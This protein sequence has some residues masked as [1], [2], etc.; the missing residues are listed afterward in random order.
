MPKEIAGAVKADFHPM[1]GLRQIGNYV[2]GEVTAKGTTTQGN[3]VIT[4]ELI[5]LDGSVQKSIAKGQYQEVEV[6]PGDLVQFIGNLTDLRD[7]LPKLAVGDIVTITNHSTV[8]SGKGNPKKI[9]K[10]VVD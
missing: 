6:S 7:K 5:D 10:V 2:K 1:V 9:F 3:P 4:L 8:P